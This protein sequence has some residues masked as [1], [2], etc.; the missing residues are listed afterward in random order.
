[1]IDVGEQPDLPR[2]GHQWADQVPPAGSILICRR[3]PNYE[4][5]ED[6]CCQ[7]PSMAQLRYEVF[8]PGPVS[9]L[10]PSVSASFRPR[11]LPSLMQACERCER[12]EVGK[13]TCRG[14]RIIVAR[15]QLIAPDDCG[16]ALHVLSGCVACGDSECGNPSLSEERVCVGPAPLIVYPSCFLNVGWWADK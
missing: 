8:P 5:H 15:A 4:D 10:P 12:P 14:A 2:R 3:V 6:P 9:R 16:W 11:Y 7:H 1:M 13:K